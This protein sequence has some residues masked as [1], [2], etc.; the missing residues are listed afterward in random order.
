MIGGTPSSRSGI[1]DLSFDGDTWFNVNPDYEEWDVGRVVCRHRGFGPPSYASSW[2]TSNKEQHVIT[3]CYGFEKSLSECQFGTNLSS[4]ASSMGL[5]ITCLPAVSTEF[6]IA[7]AKMYT[8]M[9]NGNV[10][11][12]VDGR[13]GPICSPRY[14]GENICRTICRQLGYS[15]CDSY[16]VLTGVSGKVKDLPVLGRLECGYNAVSLKDCR[17]QR[18]QNQSCQYPE[19]EI[20]EISCS[21]YHDID[22]EQ[23]PTADKPLPQPPH[24]NY[25]L[26]GNGQV[27]A[28]IAFVV[29]A[30][31]CVMFYLCR[32]NNAETVTTAT[33]HTRQHF[34]EAASSVSLLHPPRH[35]KRYVQFKRKVQRRDMSFPVHG[36]PMHQGSSLSYPT[37]PPPAYRSSEQIGTAPT[38]ETP[39]LSDPELPTY[40][41]AVA[42]KIDD[43][44]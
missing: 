12:F 11:T 14:P 10:L 42:N 31:L 25:E 34:G 4:E 16:P 41:E 5:R 28:V 29:T 7:L 17:Y 13:W 9:E 15:S 3:S 6:D 33:G 19:D 32:K 21:T 23:Y 43:Y 22:Y 18:L 37:M 8:F 26:V 44:T 1:V 35:C 39:S 38:E 2:Y 36:Y 24:P 40:E 30:F 27:M 20:L